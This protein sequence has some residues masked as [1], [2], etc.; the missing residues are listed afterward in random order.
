MFCPNC[1]TENA[2]GA[3]FC[4]ACGS[5]MN[6]APVEAPVQEAAPAPVMTETPAPEKKDALAPVKALMQKV[7]PLVQKYKLFI[8]G[9]LGI[10][11][12]VLCISILCAIFS[13]N[14]FIA[15]K[16]SI[17]VEVEDDEVII[18]YD[19]KKVKATGLEAGSISDSQTNID[20]TVLALV[21]NE[22][23]LAV[24]KGTKLTK[25][26]SD[27]SSFK[28]SEDG[29]GIAYIVNDDGDLTLNL[30]NVK[31]KKSKEVSDDIYRS[32]TISPNGDTVAYLEMKE[33]DDEAKLMVFKGNKSTKVT[34]NEVVLLGISDKAKFIYVVGENDDGESTLYVY[35]KKG[36]RT[37]LGSISDSYVYF[38]DDHTQI[39]F[40]SDGKTYVSTKG[41]EAVKIASSGAYVLVPNSSEYFYNNGYYVTMP[42]DNL[43][44]KVYSCEGNIW[45]IRKNTD[46]S[47][48]LV[49]EASRPTLSEDGKYVYFYKNDE[50]KVLKV[51]H[52]DNAASKAK[53]LAEDVGDYVVTS[54]G[55]KVYYI[56]DGSV[57]CVNAKN[58]KGKKTIANDDVEGYLYINAKDVVYYAMEGDV[59]ASKNGGKGKKIASDV[60]YIEQTANGVVYI[61][62]EDALFATKGAKKPAK[63]YTFDN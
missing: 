62:T 12:L 58:G 14:G 3:A 11:A 10:V 16:H 38:N 20:G 24:V 36:D 13:G 15:M 55:K 6:A 7:A 43:F 9:A 26:A 50:L 32:Y 17:Q 28:L 45:Y 19:A 59:Y 49:N 48:K 21:T 41:K 1:G 51:S 54:N 22:G 27:V 18:L 61:T 30:Y 29:T 57:Y 31:T 52:G 37:K 23:D 5:A 25:V 53:V 56:S 39:C 42:T 47:V 40:Y 46:K 4:A 63:V 2:E 35:N 60:E 33:D 8:A 34:S 44:N